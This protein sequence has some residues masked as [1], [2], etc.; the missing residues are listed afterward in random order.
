MTSFT[1]ELPADENEAILI[2]GIEALIS[3][4]DDDIDEA[5]EQIFIVLFDIIDAVSPETV[6]II[7]S[8]TLCIIQ[9]NDGK[10]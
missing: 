4:V 10:F 7:I 3:I 6:N 5:E 8:M 1:V 2:P 9:D